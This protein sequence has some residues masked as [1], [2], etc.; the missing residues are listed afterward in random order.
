MIP[1]VCATKGHPFMIFIITKD[2]VNISSEIIMNWGIP[3][4]TLS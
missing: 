1:N 3:E 2:M 4:T